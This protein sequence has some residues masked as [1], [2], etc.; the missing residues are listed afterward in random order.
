LLNPREQSYFTLNLT[1]NKR[2]SIKGK[3]PAKT[4]A[5]Q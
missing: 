3:S 4:L 5:S 2:K 1:K